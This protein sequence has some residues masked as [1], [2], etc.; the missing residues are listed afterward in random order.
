VLSLDE[1]A[2]PFEPPGIKPV[3][4]DRQ[5]A[6]EHGSHLQV[7]RSKELDELAAT[8]PVL[9]QD[10]HFAGRRVISKPP[11]GS[12]LPGQ[13]ILRAAQAALLNRPHPINYFFED[14]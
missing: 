12:H 5:G 7:H 2:V 4:Q 11:A 14:I 6:G 8:V 3:A 9:H 13:G 1:L 10:M